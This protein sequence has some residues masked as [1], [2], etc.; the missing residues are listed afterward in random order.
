MRSAEFFGVYLVELVDISTVCPCILSLQMVV[1]CQDF[2]NLVLYRTKVNVG[3]FFIDCRYF[4][5][6]AILSGFH[7][8]G[9]DIKV[10]K[11]HYVFISPIDF[12][13]ETSCLICYNCAFDG[14]KLSVSDQNRY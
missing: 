12:N 9:N 10:V 8:D 6:R 2:D 14:C 7:Q 11:D 3:A 4:V 5:C 13:W 1:N